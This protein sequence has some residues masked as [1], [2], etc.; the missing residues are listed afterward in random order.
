MTQDL[1][2]FIKE[3]RDLIN[4]NTKESWNKLYQKVQDSDV[5]G[6]DWP[7]TTSEFTHA[8]ISTGANPLKFL[9]YIPAAYLWQ[10]DNTPSF[11]IPN[12]VKEI[13]YAAFRGS[14]LK[15]LFIPDSVVYIEE[16]AL[17][18][19][20]NLEHVSLPK[21][22][23]LGQGIFDGSLLD[24]IEFRGTCKEFENLH[25]QFPDWTGGSNINLVKC[26]DGI[27]ELN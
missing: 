17:A 4:Q 12:H 11:N 18:D 2:E 19:C 20:E 7:L 6:D 16:Y 24:E 5:F 13:H 22:K 3:N 15:R 23:S 26:K 25:N 1:I 27:V 21:V 9:D 8:I 14:N 10:S